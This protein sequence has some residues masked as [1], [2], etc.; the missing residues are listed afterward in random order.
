MVIRFGNKQILKGD[1]KDYILFFFITFPYI[2]PQYIENLIG[3]GSVLYI[4][5]NIVSFAAAGIYFLRKGKNIVKGDMQS[6]LLFLIVMLEYIIFIYSTISNQ[7]PLR[8]AA[9]H[10]VSVIVLCLTISLV[11]GNEDETYA[12]LRT[13]QI[14]TLTYCLINLLVT[15][16]MPDGIPN[17]TGASFGHR[18]YLFGNVNSTIRGLYPGICCSLILDDKN[19]K[20]ISLSTLLFLLSFIYIILRIHIMATTVICILFLALWVLFKNV[21]IK[22]IKLIYIAVICVVLFVEIA[23]V[24]L[25]TNQ[26][27]GAFISQIFGKS[28]DFSGRRA[29]WLMTIARIPGKLIFGNGFLSPD[30]LAFATGNRYGSHNF[31]LDLVF[32][33]GIVGFAVMGLLWIMPVF[34]FKKREISSTLYIMIGL[35]C[36]LFVM[37]LSEP[38]YSSEMRIIP[39]FY[40]TCLLLMRSKKIRKDKRGSLNE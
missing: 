38:F 8:P 3:D 39:L 30:S 22:H 11:S 32:Q 19:G 35:C 20:K 17:F 29:L 28:L 26:S 31:Y 1:I 12:F 18:Y 27:I 4:I 10:S 16:V 40:V 2:L 5:L 33:R 14:V 36:A 13:V 21:F 37:F 7:G 6:R 9:Y 34:Y 24:L 25:P 15:I 23:V